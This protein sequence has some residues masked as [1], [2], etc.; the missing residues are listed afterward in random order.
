M[1]KKNND[2]LKRVLIVSSGLVF[3]ALMVVPTLG[4]LKNNNSNSPQGNQSGQEAT[5]PREKLEEMVKGYEKILERE[6]D[7]PTALQG[8]AQ[9]R[10]Q[11]KD[12]IGAREPLEKLYQKYPD[13][14]EVML[15]LYGTRLQTQDVSGAKSILEKLVKNY[16]QEPKFKEELTRLNQAIAAASKQQTPEP[17]K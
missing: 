12:F 1:P 17:K 2:A 9:A 11:L 4:L 8:L 16:P 14:L 6:P 5:I 15:V 13:N 10:L 3:L 7:N